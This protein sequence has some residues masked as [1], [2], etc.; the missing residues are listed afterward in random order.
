MPSQPLTPP[1]EKM[2]SEHRYPDHTVASFVE[3]VDRESTRFQAANPIKRGTIYSTTTGADQRVS[4]SYPLLYFL[5]EVTPLG[6]SDVRGV[7]TDKT[8]VWYWSTDELAENAY[9]ASLQYFTESASYPIFTRTSTVRRKSYDDAPTIA[10]GSAFTGLTSVNITAGGTGYTTATG[11]IATGATVEFVVSGGAL[12]EGVI[13]NE[14]SAV[15]SGGSIT[16][17]GDG[18]GATATARI[19]PA[20]AVL[21]HQ[22]KRE[23]NGNDPQSH[24]FVEIIRVYRAITGPALA[25]QDY[26]QTW[27][28]SVPYVEQ[29]EPAGNSIGTNRIDITPIDSVR[30][31]KKTFD[32]TTLNPVFSTY[33]NYFSNTANLQ[34]PDVLVSLT[35]V[36]S[37]TIGNGTYSE[38]AFGSGSGTTYFL[39]MS[40][41]GSAQGAASKMLDVLVE[42]KQYWARNVPVTSYFFFLQSPVTAAAI[43]SQL[44]TLT[45]LTITAWPKFVPQ[46]HTIITHGAKVSAEARVKSAFQASSSSDGSSSSDTSGK[47][48]SID[49]GS[50][51]RAIRIPPVIHGSISVGGTVLDPGT[52][53]VNVTASTTDPVSGAISQ[54]VL[55][56]CLAYLSPTSFSATSVT[57]IPTTGLKI[58]RTDVAPYR[59]GWA[60]VS[61]DVVNFADIA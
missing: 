27:D 60:R 39:S 10:Y 38:A 37:S 23:L 5:K 19:Q 4:D 3:L 14:G 45:G 50:S 6:M 29:E 30:Q 26:D 7:P 20:A 42:I 11:A 15:S 33:L 1:P 43:L 25:G 56:S 21:I 31:K 17:T 13:T 52:D 16:I 54:N 55:Q 12:I 49:V 35:G 32:P 24:E 41:N 44:Q 2:I 40:T 28:V 53:A 61:A 18:T 22:E 9:N 59:F 47:G 57:A 48:Y 36:E 46:S 34:L 51:I 58:L 8:V